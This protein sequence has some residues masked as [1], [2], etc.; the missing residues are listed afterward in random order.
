MKNVTFMV[1]GD[2][3]LDSDFGKDTNERRRGQ[4]EA[5]DAAIDLVKKYGFDFVFIPGDLFDKR[6]PDPET[7]AYVKNTF[8]RLKR[9]DFVIAPGNHDPYT[10]DSPYYTENWPENVHVF[11]ESSVFMF[12]F[13]T[14][15]D[16]SNKEKIYNENVKNE[17][18]GVRVYGAAFD[19]HFIRDTMLTDEAGRM[20]KLA[21]GFVNVLLMHGTFE[22]G[23]TSMNPLD[24]SKIR[25]CGFSFC[26]IGGSHTHRIDGPILS[27]GVL[28]PRN[29]REHGDTGVIVGE[30]TENDRLVTEFIPINKLYYDICSVSVTEQCDLSPKSLAEIVKGLSKEG[31]CVHVDL[32]GKARYGEEINTVALREELLGYFSDAEVSDLTV[33]AEN[34][35]GIARENS[36]RGCFVRALFEKMADEGS[37]SAKAAYTQEEIDGAANVA[38]RAFGLGGN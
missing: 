22:K 38:L 27:S 35:A 23:K 36:P 9:T 29:F 32:I 34:L 4:R 28:Y 18:R 31:N 37:E 17:R 13:G 24:E 33:K 30:F 12:E 16:N 26:A 15:T 25:D 14:D 1:M 7:V 5:F 11:K 3:H 21:S 20:P 2:V 19:G 6:N 10:V 8:A